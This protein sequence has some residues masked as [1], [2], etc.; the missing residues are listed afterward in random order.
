MLEMIFKRELDA[1]LK[2]RRIL[3]RERNQIIGAYITAHA[4]FHKVLEAE[5]EKTLE[6]IGNKKPRE[7]LESHH[8]KKLVEWFK[9]Y[10]KGKKIVMV[11]NDGTRTAKEKTEQM[12]LGLCP[13]AADLYIPHLHT[14]LEMKRDSTSRLSAK[15]VECRD[16]VINECG[17]KYIVGYGFDDARRKIMEIVKNER[18]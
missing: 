13:G 1:L 5:L 10:F 17:D 2:Q 16:Y 6:Y 8:Q 15:Q 14:W 3:K 11:R 12:L 18:I 4:D 7:M 9:Q